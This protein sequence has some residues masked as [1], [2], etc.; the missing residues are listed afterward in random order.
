MGSSHPSG[1]VPVGDTMTYWA[2]GGFEKWTAAFAASCAICVPVAAERLADVSSHAPPS[3]VELGYGTW[4]E[5]G[6]AGHALAPAATP[7]QY[8]VANALHSSFFV[9][10]PAKKA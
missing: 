2:L 10:I 3:T 5:R 4:P 6:D 7:W 1:S 9:P 8:W